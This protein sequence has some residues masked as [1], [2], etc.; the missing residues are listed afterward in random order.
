MKAAAQFTPYY[1]DTNT[2]TNQ[3]SGVS[4]APAL[5]KGVIIIRHTFWNNLICVHFL[6]KYP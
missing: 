3:V 6:G 2:D 1:Y 5:D 4:Q